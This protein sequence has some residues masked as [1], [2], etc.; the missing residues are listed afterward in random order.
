MTVEDCDILAQ[1]GFYIIHKNQ[2]LIIG[3]EDSANGCK[4]DI[5]RGNF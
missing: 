3:K 4:S 1:Q 5:K 2:N